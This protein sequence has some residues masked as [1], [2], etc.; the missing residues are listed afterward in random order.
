[1]IIGQEGNDHFLIMDDG[2]K[3]LIPPTSINFNLNIQA[4]MPD[5]TILGAAIVLGAAR[6]EISYWRMLAEKRGEE[7]ANL[8][9]S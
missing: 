9:S 5:G 1:M 7:L 8:K 3:L 4:S 6:A 2:T